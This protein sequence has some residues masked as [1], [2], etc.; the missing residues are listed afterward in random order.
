[1]SDELKIDFEKRQANL[2]ALYGKAKTKNAKTFVRIIESK[3][4]MLGHPEIEC[5]ARIANIEIAIHPEQY[6]SPTGCKMVHTYNKVASRRK[7]VIFR[8]I[9]GSVAV[10]SSKINEEA[11][12]VYPTAMMIESSTLAMAVIRA[13]VQEGK[14]ELFTPTKFKKPKSREI[15][16]KQVY[17]PEESVPIEV[18]GGPNSIEKAI[19]EGGI[20]GRCK[21][22]S[23]QEILP[24]NEFHAIAEVTQDP[25]VDGFLNFSPE[26]TS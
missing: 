12:I 19:V 11:E 5:L 8:T 6:D 7:I 4:W 13:K 1:L 23:T 10:V 16:E 25:A 26:D 15:T 3:D 21:L 20:F 2:E 17:N 14:A 24:G 18:T 9:E 22:V